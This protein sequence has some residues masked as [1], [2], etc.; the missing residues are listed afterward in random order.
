[1]SDDK[2]PTEQ[3]PIDPAKPETKSNLL[4]VVAIVAFLAIAGW[5]VAGVAEDPPETVEEA[6]EVLS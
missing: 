4:M 5:F 2:N 3:L 6:T 1:M